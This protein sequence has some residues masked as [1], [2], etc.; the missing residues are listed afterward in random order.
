MTEMERRLD[1]YIPSR[2]WFDRQEQADYAG[3]HGIGHITRVLVWAAH[4][5]E[6]LDTP[7]RHE[8][9]FWA[10]GLH[11]IKR[12][13]DGRDREHGQRAAEWVL[14][15]FPSKLPEVA[16]TLDLDLIAS[17]CR[18]HV[19]NDHHIP[20]A[21]WAIE[22]KIL[23]DADGLERVRIWDLDASR[24]RLRRISP[25]LE[26]LAWDLMH[27]SVAHGNDAAAVRRVAIEMELWK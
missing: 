4:I 6:R 10:A 13:T 19:V 2:E 9:L 26:P 27:E 11:D 3:T 17:L 16:R 14:Q 5:A 24:L 25:S 18:H 23:K 1:R 12:W 7:V 8:E 22:L 15:T 20:A 21:A